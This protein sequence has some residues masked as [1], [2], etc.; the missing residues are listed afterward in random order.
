MLLAGDIGGT[1]TL[2]EIGRFD[3]ARWRPAFAARYAAAAH[4][5]F[6]EV[7][8]RFLGE[9][10]AAGGGAI[11]AACFG[12]AGP[13]GAGRVRL[14]NLGWTLEA[15]ALAREFRIPRV[16]LVNDFAAAASGIERLE[17]SAL[18]VLQAGVAVARAP[19][20]VLGAGTGL[21]VAGL[22]W[23]GGCYRVL[24]GEAGHAAFAPAD[25]TQA[26]LWRELH[27][28]S[29]R[30]C[31]EDVVSGPGLA[32]IDAF[33]RRRRGAPPAADAA[34]AAVVARALAGDAASAQALDLFIDC[35][36]AAAGDLAL[37][38]LPFGGVYVAGGIAPKILP[39]LREGGFV[40]AFT[41]KG[42]YAATLARLPLAVVCEERLGLLGCASLAA[43]GAPPE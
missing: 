21:G 7:L 3:G 26:A 8:R 1:K 40:A 29:G 30:V 12:A 35:Y 11:E 10:A 2:L 37:G 41:A 22:V 36:G 38:W 6:D 17:A 34:P 33:V 20:L 16:E 4:D 42:D 43:R 25:E 14:T 15:A 32:R 24:A 28:Q 39:R 18:A 13:V 5:G 9:W 19:R 23:A 31:V 27:A